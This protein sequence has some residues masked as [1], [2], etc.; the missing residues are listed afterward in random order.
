MMKEQ[1]L[2]AY[3]EWDERN[4]KC[5][6]TQFLPF[7]P[8]LKRKK[9]TYRRGKKPYRSAKV[10]EVEKNNNQERLENLLEHLFFTP[11][12]P[13]NTENSIIFRSSKSFIYIKNYCSA[14]GNSKGVLEVNEYH[15]ETM[16][17]IL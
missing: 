2:S 11:S 9:A 3:L 14:S 8:S 5:E 15:S 7:L 4:F 13:V 1:I 17:R 10:L 16:L 6:E 12:L